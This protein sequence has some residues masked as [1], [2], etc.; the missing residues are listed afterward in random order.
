MAS[1]F[2]DLATQIQA[3][4]DLPQGPNAPQVVTDFL[5]RSTPL[6]F[7]AQPALPTGVPA[8]T[9]STGPSGPAGSGAVASAPQSGPLAPPGAAGGDVLAGAIA[10][11]AG[12]GTAGGAAGTLGASPTAGFDISQGLHGLTGFNVAQ[13]LGFNSPIDIHVSPLGNLSPTFHTGSPLADTGL[14]QA[15][16]ILG[17]IFGFPTSFSILSALGLGALNPAGMVL[18]LPGIIQAG[19]NAAGL[20][21]S[22]YSGQLE[23]LGHAI[24]NAQSPEEAQALMADVQS[25]AQAINAQHGTLE[26]AAPGTSTGA[27]AGHGGTTALGS[28]FTIDS[29]GNITNALGEITG[30]SLFGGPSPL[31]PDVPDPQGAPPGTPGQPGT[32]S[33]FPGDVESGLEGGQVGGAPGG[34]GDSGGGAPGGSADSPGM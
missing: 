33:G 29:Q 7:S 15:L 23:S 21:Q 13:E 24:A 5:G 20:G 31:P 12:G 11:E 26:F 6:S 18:A 28:G 25:I 22:T 17:T 8:P 27:G 32:P 16:G 14:N 9:P 3:R 34:L 10:N 2:D 19:L 1:A 4:G 30:H